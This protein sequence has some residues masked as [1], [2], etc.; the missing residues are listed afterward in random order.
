MLN[1]AECV[2]NRRVTVVAP[3]GNH[4]SCVDTSG[5]NANLLSGVYRRHA[6]S[7]AAAAENQV[8]LAIFLPLS[9]TSRGTATT[10]KVPV[11]APCDADVIDK[12][13]AW[14]VYPAAQKFPL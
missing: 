4:R 10:V 14:H 6:P 8:L 11:K 7:I 12:P 1:F 9:P 2:N 5:P 3:G 13:M